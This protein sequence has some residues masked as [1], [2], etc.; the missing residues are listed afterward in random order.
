MNLPLCVVH[1]TFVYGDYQLLKL[2]YLEYL[3]CDVICS[4]IYLVYE[5]TLMCSALDHHVTAEAEKVRTS[6]LKMSL[7]HQTG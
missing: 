4:R 7:D 5:V 2:G 6:F 1:Q 3:E